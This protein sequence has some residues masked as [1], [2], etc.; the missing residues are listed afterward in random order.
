VL[1]RW[2]EDPQAF[3]GPH[4]LPS[5]TRDDP[6]YQDNV[7][8]RGRVWP[9]LNYLTYAGLKRCGHGPAAAALAQDSVDLFAAAWAK[10][11]MPENFS[12]E[13]GIADDQPD[14]D[15]FYGWGGLMPL[16][17]INEAIDVSPW[18]GWEVNP[19]PAGTDGDWR[20]GPL[21]AFGA[22]T[23]LSV[24]QGWLTMTVDGVAV[25]KTDL[26]TRLRQ[27]ELGPDGIT[28]ECQGLGTI[29]FPGRS[30]AGMHVQFD[31]RTLAVGA[32]EGEA[33]VG[34][35]VVDTPRRLEVRWARP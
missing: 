35:P 16:I 11:Q 34:V 33:A 23:E 9:P 17:G 28:F 30:P 5:V 26:A 24:E 18:A 13:T 22:P 21:L 25:L 7:Y 32:R 1:L 20:L 2:L 10:R 29:V 3:G 14:T 8:W 6:A 31:G 15:T 19:R 12:A 27:I 4:R